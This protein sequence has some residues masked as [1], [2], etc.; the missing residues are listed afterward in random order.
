LAAAMEVRELYATGLRNAHAME[1]QALAIMKPQL[2]RAKDYPQ[3]VAQL[4]KHISETEGQVSRLESLLDRAG[5]KPSVIKDTGLSMVG[6]MAAMGHMPAADEIL[7]DSFANYAF[8]N[9]E[10]AAYKSL[11]ALAE[12][13][14][15][16]DALPALQQNLAEEEAMADWLD[17]NVEALTA[18]YIRHHS[19]GKK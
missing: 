18:E 14:G 7:K 19:A 1:R 9:Y 16:T 6:T 5:S 4:Q 11:I 15:N 17:L 12:E 10:M 2:D 13:T 3:V 8:E